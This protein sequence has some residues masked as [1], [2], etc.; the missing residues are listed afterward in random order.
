MESKCHCR[1]CKETFD[2]YM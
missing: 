2:Y 1:F